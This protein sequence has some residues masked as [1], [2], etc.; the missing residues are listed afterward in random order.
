MLREQ[1]ILLG[2]SESAPIVLDTTAHAAAPVD[3]S[4]AGSKRARSTSGAGAAA[5]GPNL[6]AFTGTPYIIVPASA[7]AL[8][9]MY[10]AEAFFRDGRFVAPMDARSAA[11]GPK[12]DRVTIVRRDSYGNEARF[13]VT[14]NVHLFRNR[15]DWMK[16][17]AVFAQGPEWQFKGW[18]W[19]RSPDRPDITPAEIF[20][21]CACATHA[22]ARKGSRSR[23]RVRSRIHPCTRA[24][25]SV[26]SSRTRVTRRTRTLP[27]GPSRRSSSANR[28]DTWMRAWQPSFGPP[29]TRK[30]M[31]SSH[32]W[33]PRHP[34]RQVRQ[35]QRNHNKQNHLAA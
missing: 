21:R 14:D 2:A 10:N 19:G 28:G 27:S 23:A 22:R 9:N 5:G 29:W 3:A 12:P 7:T 18:R 6:D 32:I 13:H 15:G 16:V 25:V 35:L 11:A 30:F 34:V 17:V 31:S 26:S 4:L 33:C 20:D 24:Q 8:L 1:S